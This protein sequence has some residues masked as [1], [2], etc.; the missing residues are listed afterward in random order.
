MTK[1]QIDN[2]STELNA[3]HG[4]EQAYE[5]LRA[6]KIDRTELH[7]RIREKLNTALNAIESTPLTDYT[8]PKN[9]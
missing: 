4:I 2:E 7:K 6:G 9:R 1:N 5:D 8:E 3:Y